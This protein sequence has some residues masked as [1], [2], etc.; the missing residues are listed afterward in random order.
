MLFCCSGQ[1]Q[2]LVCDQQVAKVTCKEV[3]INSLSDIFSL[4]N[5]ARP[6]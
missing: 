1:F 3:E 6:P 4:E 2:T 5:S